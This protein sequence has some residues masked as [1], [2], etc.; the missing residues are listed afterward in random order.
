MSLTFRIA[1]WFVI[2]F[3]VSLIFFAFLNA[4][5]IGGITLI[6]II[7]LIVAMRK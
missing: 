5:W 6:I 3:I 7:A 4:N 2:G 1:Y